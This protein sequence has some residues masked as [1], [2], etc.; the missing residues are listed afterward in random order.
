MGWEVGAGWGKAGSTGGEDETA[1]CVTAWEDPASWH[2]E[3]DDLPAL[4]L[5]KPPLVS[6]HL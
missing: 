1:G 2:G 5:S 3:S 4:S 6:E